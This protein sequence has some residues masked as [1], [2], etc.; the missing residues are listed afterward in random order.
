VSQ[1]GNAVANGKQM[2]IKICNY[3]KG[4]DYTV[5]T[6]KRFYWSPKNYYIPDIIIDD[7]TVVELKYQEVA[8]SAQNK[9]SQAVLELQWMHNTIGYNAVLVI[10][11]EKLR[12]VVMHDPAFKLAQAA[13]PDVK[14]VTIEEFYTLF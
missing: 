5:T 6:H 3:L 7:S 9:L 11:G 14:V 8:G 1:G 4:K 2:E 10:S 13:A 12:H